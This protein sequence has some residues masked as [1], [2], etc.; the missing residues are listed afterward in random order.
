MDFSKKKSV[1]L[2]TIDALR[3]D[4][5]SSY[6]YSKLTDPFLSKFTKRGS[7]FLDAYTNGPATPSSFSAIF[8]SIL[9]FLDGGYSPLPSSKISFPE[10]LSNHDVFTAGIHSNP[11]LTKFH[12]YGRGFDI[13]LD[14]MKY[15][16]K[17][18]ENKKFNFKQIVSKNF[19]KIFNLRK[20]T[21]NLLFKLK[22]FNK[23]K[24]VIR[25]RLPFL[26]EIILPVT[27]ASYNAPYLA[28]K[29][30][31]FLNKQDAP[32]FIWTHFMDI[33][34]P[35][36]PPAK[37]VE[38]LRGEDFSIVERNELIREIYGNTGKYEITHD[39]IEKLS[40]L[41]DAQ[42]NYV[43]EYLGKIL[44]FIHKKYKKDCLII[45]T[46][47]HGESFYEH[48]LFG[49]Q[50]SVYNELIEIPFI[51]IEK[52]ENKTNKIIK[53][54]IQL[55]DI[56]PTILDYFNIPIPDEFQGKSLIPLLRG[57]KDQF[58][59]NRVIISEC[60]QKQRRMKRNHK[61]GY[62][63]L[64]IIRGKWKYIYDEEL[65]KEMIFN[66]EDDPEEKYDVAN[67]YK[68]VLDEFRFIKK[69]HL[70]NAKQSKEKIKISKAI[71]SI[72]L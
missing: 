4:H 69:N 30:L 56:A 29:L 32:L 10:I 43:D 55:I 52:N 36:N 66:L 17:D 2:L 5:L 57:K 11:N 39:L 46:A 19:N 47:D 34:S 71:K 45:I 13:F 51:I 33:H 53:T 42:I 14:G 48:R 9:P 40:I 20:I 6:A 58:P 72:K 25:K 44:G 49:H 28:D 35:Y 60:Y 27:D 65:E 31:S 3:K 18:N 67:E 62:I 38:K 24:D 21:N 63:L 70:K 15:H 1:I 50:G 12:N 8:T 23:I 41:Y 16:I 59:S 26:T 54:P 37:N 61:E 22:G 64:A 7:V 68:D